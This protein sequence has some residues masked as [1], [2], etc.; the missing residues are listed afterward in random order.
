MPAEPP[1]PAV[2]APKPPRREFSPWLYVLGFLVLAGAILYV[3]Q[4]PS[5]PSETVADSPAVRDV[6]Q[7]LTDMDARV[8]RL[9]QRPAPD[10]S[11]IT[12]RVDAL[13][14]PAADQT[15]LAS[16]LDTL[17]GR[18]ES[19]SGR[20]Q[21]G[22]DVTKQQIDAL[23]ARVAALEANAGSI[24]AVAKRVNRVARIQEAS[25]ALA[26]GR[27]IGDLP[28]APAALVRYAHTA[29]PTEAQLRLRFTGA[30]QAALNAK[31]PDDSN[32]PFIERTWERVQGLMTIRRGNAVV[33]GNPVAITLNQ[34]E[35]A[36][37]T[38]NLSQAVTAVETLKGPP[39]EAMAG[40]LD[41]AKAVLNARSALDQ[42]ADQP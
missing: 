13:E 26:S 15:Q 25:I 24:E 11:K 9:E 22:M 17:S 30:Q 3:W 34:A 23:G 8:N 4:Y 20:D 31:P 42:M 27:P 38:G 40:W 12:T 18:I 32:A 19:L 1:E 5:V 2:I 10:L 35:A 29:P 41:E 39:A 21:S 16:R 37:D 33:V 28:N 14:R 7:R 6:G 36:L